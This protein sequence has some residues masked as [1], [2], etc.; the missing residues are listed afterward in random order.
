MPFDQPGA[1]GS[2][3]DQAIYQLRRSVAG[4]EVD[5]LDRVSLIFHSLTEPL[6]LDANPP[7]ALPRGVVE[8]DG[9]YWL[10]H[11]G[12]KMCWVAPIPHWLGG[13]N[14]N[15]ALPNPI[16]IETPAQGFFIAKRLMT[17]SQV[18]WTTSER[19]ASA[20]SDLD[21]PYL[22]EWGEA[23]RICDLLSQIESLPIA[24]PTADRGRWQREDPT[25]GCT[26]GEMAFTK[27]LHLKNRPGRA[28][29]SWALPRNGP[30]RGMNQVV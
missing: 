8:K 24:L 30:T 10:T 1:H 7:L 18:S 15:F 17:G 11:S 5:R 12:I 26:R 19:L 20:D 29:S 23:R 16:R 25:D 13:D 6:E 2:L 27:I 9:K 3:R 4:L 14:K 21:S 28:N 22:C